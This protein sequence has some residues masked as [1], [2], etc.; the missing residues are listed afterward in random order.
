M[1]IDVGL[2]A[3][4]SLP[5]PPTPPRCRFDRHNAVNVARVV[6]PDLSV[7]LVSFLVLLACRKLTPPSSS[8]SPSP[9]STSSRVASRPAAA[10]AAIQLVVGVLLA[11]AGIAHPAV[12]SAVYLAA[13]LGGA[14]WWASYRAI[15]RCVA[16]RAVL[17][18]YAAAHLVA[19]HLYQFQSVQAALAPA[20]LAARWVG[21]KAGG[22][23]AMWVGR[24][25]G[26]PPPRWAQVG[27]SAGLYVFI[28]QF[29]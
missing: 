8:F 16:P 23:A 25:A 22:W 18:A 24:K 15:G 10:V 4:T 19:L 3:L 20:S 29:L 9:S 5:S 14:T 21:H 1:Q 28:G 26:S 27:R 13:F 11:A 7:F 2:V 12:L 6:A 17:L